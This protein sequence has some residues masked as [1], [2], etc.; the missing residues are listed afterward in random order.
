MRSA[1][2]IA[3]Q[4][5]EEEAA[6]L[7][8]AENANKPTKPGELDTN[9]KLEKSI[10]V[11]TEGAI[12]DCGKVYLKG[13]P[14][15][16]TKE[17]IC[18]ECRLPR[19]LYPTTGVGA[20]PPPDPDREYCQRHPLIVKPGYDVHGNPFA[21]DKP[22]T[23]KKK[24]S[25][26]TTSNTP[27]SSPPS[28]PDASMGGSFKQPVPEKASSFPTVK[29]PNCPR[30][31]VVTRVA[32]HLDRCLG[33]SGRNAGRNKT[34]QE[35]SSAP[36]TSHAK[37]PRPAGED[38]IPPTLP[39]KKKSNT[40]KK[41]SNKKLPLPSKLKNETTV[42]MAV[43]ESAESIKIASDHGGIKKESNGIEVSLKN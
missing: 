38:E 10:R 24:Q 17:I 33:L 32:Q 3:R 34:P 35:S 39:K 21:T 2:V 4:R 13:N 42:D 25:T 19:L 14:L 37:R 36:N 6:R 31:F 40:P 29:C 16:T 30:Y 20:R 7:R 41:L 28:T 18:P 5:A 26:N 11:E 43:G 9:D 12:F 8:D 22:N 1:V 15:Q 27:V 23:K